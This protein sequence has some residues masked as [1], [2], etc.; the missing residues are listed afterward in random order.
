VPGRV[1]SRVAAGTNGLL[2]DGATP[3]T[4]AQDVL[5]ELFGAGMRCVE[6]VGRG[7]PLEPE[8]EAVLAAVEAGRSVGGIAATGEVSAAQARSALARLEAAGL[9]VRSGLGTY[10]RTAR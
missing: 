5:D 7:R 9:I 10:E 6:P 4:C 1:T 2:R 3:V 8:L